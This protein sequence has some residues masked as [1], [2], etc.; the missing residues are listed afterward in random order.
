MFKRAFTMIEL[1]FVI[2]VMGI[3]GKFGTEFLMQAY[4]NFFYSNMANR[5][6]KQSEAAVTQIAARLQYRIKGS[7]VVQSTSDTNLTWV[8]MDIEGWRGEWNSTVNRNLPTWSGFINLDTSF[9]PNANLLSSPKTDTSKAGAIINALSYTPVSNLNDSAIIF[10]GATDPTNSIWDSPGVA[11]TDQLN[12]LAH[13]IQSLGNNF[14]P[15]VGTGSFLGVDV[16]EFYKLAWTAYTVSLVGTNL[17]LYYNYQP[18]QGENFNLSGINNEILMENVVDFQ[19]QTIGDLIKIKVCVN[20]NL[21]DGN[22]SIC[23]EK[24]VF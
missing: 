7:I 23:K 22:Y 1:I 21:V 24:T 15:L 18:W 11:V 16:Y 17:I 4:E 19:Y 3:L 10:I 14:Q 2:V 13:P 8:G 12:E 20:S 9:I 5:L 6:Q